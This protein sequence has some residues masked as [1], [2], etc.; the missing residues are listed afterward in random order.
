[1]CKLED[2]SQ[3]AINDSRAFFIDCTCVPCSYRN[4]WDGHFARPLRW[5]S[6]LDLE[7]TFMVQSLLLR[8][9]MFTHTYIHRAQPKLIMSSW[10]GKETE[11]VGKG[12]GAL[13]CPNWLGMPQQEMVV[14]GWLKGETRPLHLTTVESC[15]DYR[16][17]S[18]VLTCCKCIINANILHSAGFSLNSKPL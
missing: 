17:C 14:L 11:K 2:Y 3:D 7:H 5:D 15:E 6:L 1:M 4:R 9:R 13:G 8:R 12:R 18:S 16:A 10:Y